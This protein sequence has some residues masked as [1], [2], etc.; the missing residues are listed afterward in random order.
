[1]RH[2]GK[3]DDQFADHCTAI[4]EYE[5]A[6]VVVETSALE[7]QGFARRI[8]EVVG[9]NGSIILQPLEPPAVRLLLAE[10][11]GGY[12]A[13]L[14]NIDIHQ[15]PRYEADLVELAQCISNEQ[16]LPYT[17]EHDFLAQETLLRACGVD[18]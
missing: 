1:M 2:D 8:F 6:L 5:R 18:I 14:H 4:L 9:S 15:L 16:P 7:G 13:G 10:P 17:S 12:K 11:A 3:H